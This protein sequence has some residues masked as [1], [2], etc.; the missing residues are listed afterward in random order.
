MEAVLDR[1][2]R[3]AT[4]YERGGVHAVFAENFGDAPF[5]KDAVPPETVAAMATAGRAIR[6]AIRL[7]V[8]FNVLRNDAR[9][10]LA[11]CSACGGSFIRVN[12][13]CGAMVTDQGVIEGKAFETLRLRSRLCPEARIFADVHVKHAAPLA[14]LPIE[15]AARDTLDRGLAD[16]LILSGIGTGQ[17]T[18]LRDVERVRVACPND[19]LFIGSGVT[20]D[21]A[22]DYL[23]LADGIIVGTSLKRGGNVRETVDVKR[24][25]ALAQV[26]ARMR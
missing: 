10:A 5:T 2:V 16:G 11:L 6:D 19:R 21:T 3:D 7:P 18:D 12:V 14:P 23:K 1:A 25:T 17:A 8:G 4:A 13:H 20:A 15:I 9:T 24:V 26:V 22:A